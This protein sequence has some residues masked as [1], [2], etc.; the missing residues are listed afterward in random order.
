[1]KLLKLEGTV[2]MPI[3]QFTDAERE[4]LKQFALRRYIKTR[5]IVGKIYYS[6]LD[7]TTRKL[8]VRGLMKY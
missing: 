5:K 6:D 4:V 2:M 3:D 1:M 8:L 7:A